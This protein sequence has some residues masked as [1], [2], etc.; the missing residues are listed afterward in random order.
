VPD[1]RRAERAE[2][3]SVGR[4]RARAAGTGAVRPVLTGRAMLLGVL[5]VLLVVVLAS[6]VNRYLGSRSDVDHAGQ[7]LKQDSAEL[8][9]LSALEAQYSD[10]GFI[11]Q[12][13]RKQLQFAMPGDIVYEVVDRGQKSQ[14]EQ[15]RSTSTSK[16]ATG[17]AWN[18]R[19]WD[20]VRAAGG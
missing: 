13:A 3:R 18:T 20:S 4:R 15:T 19:L 6:P 8:K 11:Q 17:P 9:R 14:I 5:I 7:Q 2:L 1:S 10:P 12:Q 16:R